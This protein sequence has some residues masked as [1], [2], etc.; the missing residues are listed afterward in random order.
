MK[1]SHLFQ[2]ALLALAIMLVSGCVHRER[3][4][5]EKP[6]SEVG[7]EVVVSQAPPL[8][9]VESMNAAPGPGYVWV[10]GE[11]DWRGQ[12]VWQHGRWALP[13]RAGA[14]WVSSRYETRGDSKVFIRGGWK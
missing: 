3:V 12:W 1:T 8:P 2:G 7:V 13:P 4:V 11:W 14:I 10:P 9:E 5:H 6:T